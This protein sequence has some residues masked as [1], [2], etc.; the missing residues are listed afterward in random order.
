MSSFLGGGAGG[1]SGGS[2]ILLAAPAN[3]YV[4]NIT[5]LDSN[6][7]TLAAPYATLQYAWDHLR[8][9]IDLG[10]Q[11]LQINCA[12]SATAYLLNTQFGWSGAGAVNIIG[13]GS[14]ITKIANLNMNSLGQFLL[15]ANIY[16][17]GFTLQDIGDG[18]AYY[19]S[20]I[21]VVYLGAISND[22]V[23]DVSANAGA[24]AGIYSVGAQTIVYATIKEIIGSASVA[25]F[26]CD[27]GGVIQLG[28]TATTITGS[29]TYG[30]AF[31]YSDLG[32]NL[33]G[34]FTSTFIGTVHGPR[35]FS[36]PDSV[37]MGGATGNYG[38][39]PSGIYF[40]GD[41]PGI[42]AGGEY[43]G[44]TDFIGI[45]ANLPYAGVVGARAIVT[46]AMAVTFGSAPAGLGVLVTPVFSDGAI[47]RMG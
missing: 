35:F 47:W 42:V 24:F 41:L 13:A 28:G 9:T 40:P 1:S 45:V 25:A 17:D 18:T 43:P 37:V 10:G 4:N 15:G 29:P 46:D 3:F 5:G 11:T 12:A 26:W 19:A 8:M 2:R 34:G 36:G 21:G 38:G 7:G 27:D 6:P 20:F 33:E 22:I 31:V 39:D 32:A 44:I 30:G 23:I 16:F 14:G